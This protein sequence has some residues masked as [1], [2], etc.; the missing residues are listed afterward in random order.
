MTLEEHSAFNHGIEI[1]AAWFLLICFLLLTGLIYYL[2]LVR[3]PARP[4]LPKVFGTLAVPSDVFS[5]IER[6]FT[7][8]KQ[9]AIDR[10]NSHQKNS[11]ELKPISGEASPSTAMRETSED[12]AAAI[13]GVPLDE[14][15][16]STPK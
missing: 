7:W 11:V 15:D 12:M 8:I 6:G 10:F 2:T 4:I 9:Q 5:R 3:V 14:E 1:F 16:I 13:I